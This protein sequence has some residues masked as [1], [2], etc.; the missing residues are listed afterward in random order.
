MAEDTPDPR[1]DLIDFIVEMMQSTGA[2]RRPSSVFWM[3][4]PSTST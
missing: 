1:P 2:L 3:R 4:S